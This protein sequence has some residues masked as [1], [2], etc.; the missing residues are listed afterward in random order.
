M[1]D[2]LAQPINTQQVI[3]DFEAEIK[4]QPMPISSRQ[5]PTG[6]HSD[7]NQNKTNPFIDNGGTLKQTGDDQVQNQTTFNDV[8]GYLPVMAGRKQRFRKALFDAQQYP[9]GMDFP[10]LGDVTEFNQ[11][12][13]FNK[14]EGMQK[15]RDWQTQLTDRDNALKEFQRDRGNKGQQDQIPTGLWDFDLDS[16]NTDS[17]G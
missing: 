11:L 3:D 8:G 13:G 16:S 14:E 17:L 15:K 12:D 10:Q 2:R 9:A 5:Y 7:H 6:D 1:R 4:A